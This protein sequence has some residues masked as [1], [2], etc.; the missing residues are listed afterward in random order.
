MALFGLVAASFECEVLS[1]TVTTCVNF[2]RNPLVAHPG[3]Q[4]QSVFS[5]S[6]ICQKSSNE[7]YVTRV[8]VEMCVCGFAG[9]WR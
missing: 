9:S 4:N 1:H 8:A 2:G 3:K 5:D 7:T 6:L